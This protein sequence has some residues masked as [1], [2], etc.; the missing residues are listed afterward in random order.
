LLSFLSIRVKNKPFPLCEEHRIPKI[1]IYVGGG[2]EKAQQ[3][4]DKMYEHFKDIEGLDRAPAFNERVT[5][6]IYVTQGN[7]DDKIL[8]PQLFEKSLVY[9][10]PTITGEHK[11]YRLINPATPK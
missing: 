5:S 7:R 2:K 3:V 8:Y 9:Y 10:Q 11:D 1:V 4:L 6:F